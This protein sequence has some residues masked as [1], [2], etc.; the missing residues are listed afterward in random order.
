VSV[1]GCVLVA[2]E[3]THASA[4]TTVVHALTAHYRARG[5][6]VDC[7]A[8][9]A[10]TSPFIEEAVIH[11]KGTFDLATEVDLFAAQ[12]SAQLRAARHHHLL[13]CDKTIVN[14]LAYAR[15]ILPTVPG[16]REAAVL[17]AMTA[18]CRAWAPTY[19]AVFHLS[20]RYGDGADPFRA[21]VTHLQDAT[22]TAVRDVCATVGLPLVDVPEGLDLPDRVAWIARWV[23][24]LL[25]AA[26]D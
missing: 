25:S 2:I 24:G 6:L 1:R 8:E 20:D 10:R 12:L 18:F 19:D 9:P 15:L 4:K 17:D 13:I 7:V 16:R 26:P 22:A 11:G 14:V 23:D 21:K 3:G 5:V